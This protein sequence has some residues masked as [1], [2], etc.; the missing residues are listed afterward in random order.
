[1]T[2]PGYAGKIL[3]LD[4][5]AGKVRVE[6]TPAEMINSYIGGSGANT[7]LARN[8]IS[9]GVDPLSSENPIIIGAGPFAGTVVPGGAKVFVSTRL[10]AGG[11]FAR[12]SGGGAFALMMKSCG[13]DHVVI[14]GKSPSPVYVRIFQGSADLCDASGLW[15]L[16]IYDTVDR[17]KCL[18]SPCSVIP[19]GVS[20]EK[21]VRISITSIDKGG[22]IGRGGLP[23]VM[24][25]K[26][27][28][29][30][31]ACLGST[32]IGVA[33]H[34][35]FSGIVGGLL[36]RM[37]SWPGRQL[38]LNSGM[39]LQF[40]EWWG[41]GNALA[42]NGTRALPP[43]PEKVA[44][45]KEFAGLYVAGRKPL[46]CPGC[47]MA[48]KEVVTVTGGRYSGTVC[49]G[50]NIQT[51]PATG[52]DF[53]SWV[54][55]TEVL[56]RE[57][58]DWFDFQNM[59]SLCHFLRD[60]GIL[61]AG[62]LG[63]VNIDEEDTGCYLDLARI[64]AR[65]EGFGDLLAEG[66]SGL[67][68]RL[69]P[70][71]RD[72]V[73][74]IK[75]HSPVFDPR[76]NYMG[77]MEFT[78]MTNPRGAHVAFGGSPTYTR[79]KSMEDFRKHGHRMGIPEGA[80]ERVIRGETFSLGRLSRYSEDWCSLFDCLGLCNRAFVNRFYGIDTITAL[81][82]AITGLDRTGADLMLAA[83]RSW[84]LWRAI[85]GRLGY[86]RKDDRPPKMWFH[87]VPAGNRNLVI[88]DYFDTGEITQ[89]GVDQM[90]DEYYQER[91]WDPVTGMPTGEKKKQLGLDGL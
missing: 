31:V 38:I 80:L 14:T 65:R 17:I 12:G 85:N 72:Y 66:L 55:L 26:N 28:K 8:L 46:G 4:L 62:D 57:G 86:S 1:V 64:T 70:E 77:T 81:F 43:T 69:G 56:N 30:V 16:D 61:T 89:A 11:T 54:K 60:R 36:K 9:P 78:Q 58:L 32:G 75:G 19:I 20:G 7:W 2:I 45:F 63:G 10:P 13:F 33:R 49:Y 67:E 68:S 79:G 82:N 18:H 47:P 74:H 84:N 51:P 91:G 24:G 40:V 83:E 35:E 23:A 53:G 71:A 59:V 6:E 22:T 39:S 42:R 34:A 15:G 44:A 5:S 88:R 41:A 25:A 50:N 90:L 52:A 3:Y 37:N 87:P 76:S 21:L 48:D 73:C 29:A 27:L